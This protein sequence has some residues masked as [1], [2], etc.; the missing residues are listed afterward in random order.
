MHAGRLLE[1][2]QYLEDEAIDGGDTALNDE[3]PLPSAEAAQAVHV[4]QAGSQRGADDLSH[5]C[6]YHNTIQ[7]VVTRLSM[8]GCMTLKCRS[9]LLLK[10]QRDMID[11]SMEGVLAMVRENGQHPFHPEQ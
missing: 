3:Q 4:Q 6:R 9:A 10:V 1:A 11:A 7:K 2:G 5:S 8:P